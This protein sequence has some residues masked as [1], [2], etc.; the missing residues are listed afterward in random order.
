MSC[1]K[2]YFLVKCKTTKQIVKSTAVPNIIT[3]STVISPRYIFT[4]FKSNYANQ[5]SIN[6]IIT[7]LHQ[8]IYITVNFKKRHLRY[9]W[10]FE[11]HSHTKGFCHF[12]YLTVASERSANTTKLPRIKMTTWKTINRSC[13]DCLQY[14]IVVTIK[15][16]SSVP[17]KV[18]VPSIIYHQRSTSH[19]VMIKS[20]KVSLVQFF[21][22]LTKRVLF[23]CWIK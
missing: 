3:D 7:Y 2:G 23:L 22:I 21:N 4:N 13:V 18:K 17:S 8:G 5:N 19:A 10:L 14:S 1:E 20:Q 12:K 15:V 6:K 9:S 11:L 16:V